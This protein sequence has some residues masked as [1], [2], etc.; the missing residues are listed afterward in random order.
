[1]KFLITSK[2]E[3]GY[4]TGASTLSLHMSQDE[5]GGCQSNVDQFKT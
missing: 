3:L 4:M 5:L 1:M 2:I